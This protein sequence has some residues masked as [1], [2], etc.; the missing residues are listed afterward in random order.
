MQI[1]LSRRSGLTRLLGLFLKFFP[2]K[3]SRS[4]LY[5]AD[6]I[7]EQNQILPRAEIY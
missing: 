5:S 1:S 7:T 3:E 4:E 6:E 2:E